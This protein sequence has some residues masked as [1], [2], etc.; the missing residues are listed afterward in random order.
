MLRKINKRLILIMILKISFISANALAAQTENVVEIKSEDKIRIDIVSDVVCPW[1]AVGYKRLSQAID[2]LEV[3]D[4]VDI[5]WHPFQLNPDMP[6]EGI[7]ADQYLMNKYRLSPEKLK[8]TRKSVAKTGKDSGFTFNYYDEMKKPN[9]FHA[10]VLLDYAKAFN[11]QTELKVRLQESYFSEKKNIGNRE[12]LSSIL[13]EVGLDA[14]EGIARLDDAEAIKRVKNDEKYWKDLG[15]HSI[16]T[17]VFD[18]RVARRG[19]NPVEAYKA[20]LVA[21]LNE[22]K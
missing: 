5:H 12:V 7:N 1:C 2:E 18:K 6:Q 15:V 11:K 22:K 20:L 21:L 4:K 17:M 9:T 19:A 10:H 16:P 3:Q 14:E 13:K 8:Q